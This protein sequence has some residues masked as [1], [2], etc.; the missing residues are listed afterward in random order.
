MNCVFFSESLP[1][2]L[3][4]FLGRQKCLFIIQKL[5]L[6]AQSCLISY[7][8][9]LCKL[10]NLFKCCHL[11]KPSSGIT[12][13]LYYLL[14]NLH[15][16]Y[17]QQVCK[18]CRSIFKISDSRL[19]TTSINLHFTEANCQNSFPMKYSLMNKIPNDSVIT[20][21]CGRQSSTGY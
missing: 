2:L 7:F 13:I 18:I 8:S 19:W 12:C 4:D 1:G 9:G 10:T 5:M 11:P 14:F 21:G 15:F 20:R 3:L 17:M 16:I 6:Q